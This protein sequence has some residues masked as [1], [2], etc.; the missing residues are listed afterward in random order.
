MDVSKPLAHIL[1]PETLEDFI[2]QRHILDKNKILYNIINSQKPVS[3]VFWGPPGCGKTTMAFI[4]SK[5][6]KLS[7]KVVS[8]VTMGIADVRKIIYKAEEEFDMF[9]KPTIMMVDEIHRFNKAQQDA[10]LPHIEKGT[11]ILIGATTENPSFSLNNALLS[12]VKVIVFKELDK[13]DVNILL[14]RASNKAGFSYEKGVTDI[15]SDYANG[16]ARKVLNTLE[17]FLNMG[18][19]DVKKED[20]KRVISGDINNAYDKTGEYHFDLIS[21]FHKSLRGSDA[22]AA[23]YWMMRML[24]GG[25]DPLYIVRRMVRFAS[26]DIGLADPNALN[27]ALNAL[28]AVR[29]LGLP[30]GDNAMVACAVYLC[31]APKSNAVY[32]LCNK[33]KEIASRYNREAVPLHLRNA[34]TKLMADLDYGKEYKYPHNFKNNII[35]QQYLPD[36]IKNERWFEPSENGVEKR[37]KERYEW[38]LKRIRNKY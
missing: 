26:E 18:K 17:I 16:D 34:P 33:V 22:D 32:N 37:M 25:E 1:R 30:E 21:A 31:L 4:F 5:L 11:I 9:Q 7:F 28:E 13:E 6:F 2:G 14:E 27:H 20:L 15:I 19:Y 12:R 35:D 3:M 24:E 8:A 38:I 10:F 36:K 23:V 29:F